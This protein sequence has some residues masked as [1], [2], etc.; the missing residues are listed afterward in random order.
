MKKIIRLT[1]SDLKRV[2]KEILN[3]DVV[4]QALRKPVSGTGTPA[5]LNAS[6]FNG[7]TVNLY[8]D[9]QNKNF[10][11]QQKINVVY[12]NNYGAVVV[13]LS[14]VR[15]TQVYGYLYLNCSNPNK[16]EF[17]NKP[18]DTSKTMNKYVYNTPLS[19]QLRK[20]WCTVNTSGASVPK[21]D[22]ASN[23]QKPTSNFA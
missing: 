17:D 11:G 22:F 19:T 9:A 23:T 21:S 20:V 14:D 16:N 12:K 3:E 1:E 10:I 7:K 8:S 6:S 4:G 2:I 5:N 15:G 18:R 13:N